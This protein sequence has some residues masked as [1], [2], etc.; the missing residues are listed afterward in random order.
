MSY[1]RREWGVPPRPLPLTPVREVG[2]DYNNTTGD[3]PQQLHQFFR[4][5]KVY[6]Y[7]PIR[8]DPIYVNH[9][10]D[11]KN[12][13]SKDGV[14]TFNRILYNI[15]KDYRSKMY[16]VEVWV[17]DS[18]GEWMIGFTKEHIDELLVA[19]TV[20]L[21]T[22]KESITRHIR[23]RKNEI[24][25]NG[26]DFY[27]DIY[28]KEMIKLDTLTLYRDKVDYRINDIKHRFWLRSM[29]KSTHVFSEIS[30]V[31]AE[32]REKPTLGKLLKHWMYSFLRTF[33]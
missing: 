25:R 1:Y 26:F 21:Y 4:S 24:I 18:Q 13:A 30:K 16:T 23:S 3:K 14:I 22:T 28:I 20:Q 32:Y 6:V 19:D 2:F 17:S 9:F 7:I 11:L 29:L 10:G 12:Y 31:F 8:K 33:R 5:I 15:L 27:H